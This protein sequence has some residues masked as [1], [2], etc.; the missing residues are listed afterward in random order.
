[1]SMNSRVALGTAAVLSVEEAAAWLPMEPEEA[2]SWLHSSGIVRSVWVGRREIEVVVWGDVVAAI[3]SEG[4]A[5][6]PLTTWRAIA[7]AIGV[8]EDTLARRR[9]DAADRAAPYF[10]DAQAARD[11]YQGL[12]APRSQEKAKP[13]RQSRPKPVESQVVDWKAVAKG[14]WPR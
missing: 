1:M 12:L 11:W 10:V 9:S 2:A 8:S 3:Q 13:R 6:G 5:E 14:K 7:Q 4:A